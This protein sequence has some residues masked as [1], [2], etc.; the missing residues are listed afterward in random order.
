MKSKIVYQVGLFIIFI[1]T[2]ALYTGIAASHDF[3]PAFSY[4]FQVPAKWITCTIAININ[5]P[6]T[7]ML[8]V[9]YLLF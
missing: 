5:Q 6:V 4:N 1:K 8:I 3:L 7:D 9:V 2:I